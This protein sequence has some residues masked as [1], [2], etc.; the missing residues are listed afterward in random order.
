MKELLPGQ[1]E[2]PM[3]VQVDNS[4]A[5]FIMSNDSVR[6]RTKHIDIRYHYVRELVE[7][8]KVQEQAAA[9]GGAVVS[10]HPHTALTRSGSA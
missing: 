7:S 8:L 9:R 2:E 4:G 5:V 10:V 3:Y 6:D 1:V